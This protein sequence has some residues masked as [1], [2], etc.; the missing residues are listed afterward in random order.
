MD[1]NR[2]PD[3]DFSIPALQ[4]GDRE[5]FERLVD[6]YADPIY[7]LVFRLLNDRQDAEDVMQETFLKALKALP[8]FEGRSKVSTWLYR[9]AVNEAYALLRK[10]RPDI[11]LQEEAE[12]QDDERTPVI[13][14]E[15]WCCL[16]EEE[17]L[18]E[19]T[20]RVMEQASRKLSL[21]LR[22]VFHLRDV[23]GLSIEDTARVLGITEATVK[24]RLLRARLKLRSELSDYFHER[25]GARQDDAHA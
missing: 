2:T 4:R 9:I 22:S 11:M 15:D 1:I 3:A 18:S 5:E 21:A 8:G 23:Q 13:Y 12:E 19:E 16:P 6:A 14:L 10:R 25:M 7:R 24:V 17:L 20:H